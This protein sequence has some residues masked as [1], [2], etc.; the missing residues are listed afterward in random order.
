MTF[1]RAT[2]E[3]VNEFFTILFALIVTDDCAFVDRFGAVVYPAPDYLLPLPAAISIPQVPTALPEQ[4]S[5][6]A[7]QYENSTRTAIQQSEL[8]CVV[9]QHST[10][11]IEW[12]F[13][14]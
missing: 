11:P 2:K 9:A 8:C 3:T 10:L 5:S 14:F 6:A 4:A 13:V 12:K 7:L 1:Q